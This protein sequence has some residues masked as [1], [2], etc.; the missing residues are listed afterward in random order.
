MAQANPLGR[1]GQVTGLDLGDVED[2]AD[3]QL[4]RPRC[5]V[6]DLQRG[7]FA[8]LRRQALQDQFEDADD[9]NDKSF[10]YKMP[11]T[12]IFKAFRAL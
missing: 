11:N 3:E 12:S 8:L 1:E 9:R 2:V 4:Q 5:L 7:A 6:G 10:L